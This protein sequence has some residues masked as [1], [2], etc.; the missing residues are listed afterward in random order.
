MIQKS[1]MPIHFEDRSGVEFERLCYAYLLNTEAWT[2][3][4]WIG[5]S[6][7][8]GGRDIVGTRESGELLVVQ[9]ANHK[10]LRFKK[11]TSD[12]DKILKSGTTPERFILISGGKISADMRS[13]IKKYVD[14]KGISE[15]EVWSGAEFEERLRRDQPLLI[16][17]FV[18]GVTFPEVEDEIEAWSRPK[19]DTEILE[20]MSACFERPAFTT[21]LYAE[22]SFPDFKKAITDT[23]EALSTGVWRLRD[24]TIIRR[25]SPRSELK[26]PAKR[27]AL[28]EIIDGLVE[29]RY[30]YTTLETS[31]K[32]KTSQPQ[33][34]QF[35]M[36]CFDREALHVLEQ[37]R[38]EVIQRFESLKRS[39]QPSSKSEEP[40]RTKLPL[41][42]HAAEKCR[43]G[44]AL[45][46]KAF[47]GVLSFE[48]LLPE[49]IDDQAEEVAV[50]L[51]T[52]FQEWLDIYQDVSPTD[53]LE[54][55]R[56][57]TKYI[58]ELENLG[59]EVYGTRVAGKLTGGPSGRDSAWPHGIVKISGIGS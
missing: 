30:A 12:L 55:R 35:S 53:H 59:Y 28:G 52:S 31:G 3:L 48:F 44:R 16:K 40:I 22:V 15:T 57:W 11:V 47:V 24:G 21:P 18:E 1:V 49:D 46:N 29:L 33:G 36:V 43:N 45:W 32:V 19:S 23:I 7:S 13:K 9:C 51:Q 54:C 38:F 14:S 37:L 26:D 56:T 27:A 41:G 39:R 2:S 58:K 10:S 5:Q 6:G 17:R 50:H 34:D 25:I 4:E 20:Q 42:L 8:D